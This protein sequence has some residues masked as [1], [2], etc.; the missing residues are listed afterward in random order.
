MLLFD[1]CYI[2]YVYC[3][4]QSSQF[5]CQINKNVCMY[6]SLLHSDEAD[7]SRGRLT[8]D[9]SKQRR[10]KSSE[11]LPRLKILGTE[12]DG[13]VMECVLESGK[14]STVVFKFNPDVDKTDDIADSLVSPSSEYSVL[15]RLLLLIL[16]CKW[17]LKQYCFTERFISLTNSYLRKGQNQ[18]ECQICHSPLTVKHILIDCPVSVHT[19]EISGS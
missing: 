18:P 19:S 2:F 17:N 14:H 13:E 11:K 6:V 7:R 15:C 1:I 12:N 3:A 16:N 8:V 4:P 9:R 5:G 10:K